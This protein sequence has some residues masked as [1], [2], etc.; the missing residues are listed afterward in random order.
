ME[1]ATIICDIIVY[2]YRCLQRNTTLILIRVVSSSSS[3]DNKTDNLKKR[4]K[5]GAD[6]L[7]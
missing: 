5:T 7:I 6:N 4:V 3:I 2:S 1:E